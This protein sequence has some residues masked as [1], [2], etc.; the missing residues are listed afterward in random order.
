MAKWLKTMMMTRDRCCDCCDDCYDSCS[1]SSLIS[2]CADCADCADSDDES[3]C[4]CC[5]PWLLCGV[6]DRPVVSRRDFVVW[7]CGGCVK[8][9]V[10]GYG[11]LKAISVVGKR[12]KSRQTFGQLRWLLIFVEDKTGCERNNGRFFAIGHWRTSVLCR[13]NYLGFGSTSNR[14][15]TRAPM[16]VKEGVPCTCASRTR[17]IIALG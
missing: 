16:S 17:V 8:G 13:K 7:C 15:R 3:L 5:C 4:D 6:A 14:A 1:S 12:L 10:T 2:C 9:G 11:S